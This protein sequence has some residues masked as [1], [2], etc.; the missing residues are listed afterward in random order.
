MKTMRQ[1]YWLWIALGCLLGNS[2]TVMAQAPSIRFNQTWLTISQNECLNRGRQGLANIQYTLTNQG[3]WW[4]A[5]SN[6]NEQGL[7]GI[8]CITKDA[9]TQAY[10]TVTGQN[11]KRCTDL[12]NFGSNRT[13]NFCRGAGG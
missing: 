13:P 6:Q 2:H 9:Q 12:V 8:S 11:D 10:V 4:M 7:I 3:N 5:A 1:R